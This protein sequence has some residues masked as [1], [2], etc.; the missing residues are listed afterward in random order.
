MNRWF[1][2]SSTVEAGAGTILSITDFDFA[3]KKDTQIPSLSGVG[4]STHAGL[5]FEFFQHFYSAKRKCG[6]Y[7]SI[8]S[9]NQA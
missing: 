2:L 4:I 1:V 8:K 7:V 6:F 3:G 9:Q 5:R